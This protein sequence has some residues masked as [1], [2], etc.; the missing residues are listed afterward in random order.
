MPSAAQ[1]EPV[2]ARAWLAWV[3]ASHFGLDLDRYPAPLV[4][5]SLASV[6]DAAS[7]GA[8]AL[9]G[10]CSPFFVGETMLL[11]NAELSGQQS[12]V[13]RPLGRAFAAARLFAGGAIQTDGSLLLVLDAAAL[14]ER[15]AACHRGAPAQRV[16]VSARRGGRALSVLV[17]D[18][19]IT[20]RTLLRNILRAAHYDVT[21][22]HDG[23][24]ALEALERMP[25]CDLVVTDLQM[26]GLD[27]AELTRAIR[28]SRWPNLPVVVVTS[29]GDAAEKRRA[30][31]AGA[32]T[33]IVKSGFDQAPF[34][35]LVLR[36]AGPSGAA[37]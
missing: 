6:A 17:V 10:L 37:P 23:S 18:D 3:L 21:V 19:S 4:E 2:D 11:R 8:S 9:R 14:F 22:A 13:I 1:S 36:L 25:A 27:G 5:G 32:D 30:L 31:A 24:A 20:M 28:S 29:V 35:D 33:Y 26:P 34:L 12:L 7:A 16:D 15:A